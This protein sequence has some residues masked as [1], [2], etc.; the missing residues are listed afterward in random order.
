MK[1]QL[2]PGLLFHS[3]KGNR[4]DGTRRTNG[5]L[6][7]L[8]QLM[9]TLMS[10]CDERNSSLNEFQYIFVTHKFWREISQTLDKDKTF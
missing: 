5:L 3:R 8:Q 9:P 10:T 2:Y 7:T 4:G 6:E 1:W